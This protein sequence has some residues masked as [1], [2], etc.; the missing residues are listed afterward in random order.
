MHLLLVG[1]FPRV[2]G[3]AIHQCARSR[4]G[5]DIANQVLE[6]QRV[7]RSDAVERAVY[8]DIPRQPASTTR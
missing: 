1:G 8:K 2:A 4:L 6:S 7:L 3:A 5:S